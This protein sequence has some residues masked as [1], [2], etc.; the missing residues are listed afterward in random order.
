M[1][2]QESTPLKQNEAAVTRPAPRRPAIALGVAFV[3]VGLV[4]AVSIKTR[5][6]VAALHKKSKKT[7]CCSIQGV[8][9]GDWHDAN[10]DG[11]GD[12]RVLDDPGIS[13]CVHAAQDEETCNSCNPDGVYL[14]DDEPAP[15]WIV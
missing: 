5:A 3:L 13:A 11:E 7:H 8:L 2:A 1:M 12:D 10:T 4:G 14:Y 9:C 6:P 15:Q